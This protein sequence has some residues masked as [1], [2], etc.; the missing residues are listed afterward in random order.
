MDIDFSNPFFLLLATNVLGGISWVIRT[1]YQRLHH[2]ESTLPNKV[3]EET[4]NKVIETVRRK[5]DEN[6]ERISSQLTVLER[7]WADR[8]IAIVQMLN[9]KKNNGDA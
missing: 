5:N 9:G 8:H 4:F 2:V 1:L 3:D 7:A 6:T